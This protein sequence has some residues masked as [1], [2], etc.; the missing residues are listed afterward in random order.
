M[1]AEA[2]NELGNESD[3]LLMVNK[4]RQRANLKALTTTGKSNIQAAIW[5][6]RRLELAMEHDR[7]FDLV[8]TGRAGVVMRAAGKKFIDGKN[9]VLPIPSLQIELSGGKLIQN[10]N[11]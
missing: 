4:V 10:P 7:F 2:A 5:K 11:Y 9:E 1:N 6:E 8:R 3:A